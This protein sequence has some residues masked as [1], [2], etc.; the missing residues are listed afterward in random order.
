MEDAAPLGPKRVE[1]RKVGGLDP[2]DVDVRNGLEG[3]FRILDC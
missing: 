3:W 1:I 2:R